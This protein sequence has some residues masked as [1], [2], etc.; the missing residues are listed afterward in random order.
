MTQLA[1]PESVVGDFDGVSLSRAGTNILL[2][3]QDDKFFANIKSTD[4]STTERQ[5]I[6]T[7][8]SHHR[9]WVWMDTDHSRNIQALPFLYLIH[10]QRWIP[11]ETGFLMPVGT[12]VST[13]VGAWNN[14]CIDCHTTQSRK[15]RLNDQKM[16]TQ[17]GQFGIACEACHGPGQEHIEA[18]R[19][20]VRRYQLWI[21]G[22]ADPTI[23]NPAR[24]SAS[25]S[26]QVCGQCHG[27]W[28]LYKN[29]DE[30]KYYYESGF[31][32]RPSDDLSDSRFFW[33]TSPT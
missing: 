6:M 7:T 16:D 15:R 3:R 24:M 28:S 32:Y 19:N 22:Q 26:S 9:Q 14:N 13:H 12:S 25:R 23:A 11:L 31:Q 10:Q 33:V 8:G 18:N 21:S 2:T 29:P 5:I 20:P 4:G 1:S 17:I 30:A 27:L